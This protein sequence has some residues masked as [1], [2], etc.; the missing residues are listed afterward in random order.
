MLVEQMTRINKSSPDLTCI[1]SLSVGACN[2]RQG[3]KSKFSVTSPTLEI[4]LASPFLED[5]R[6]SAMLN[7]G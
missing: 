7:L 2:L 3:Q 4:L 1:N 6:I 5:I